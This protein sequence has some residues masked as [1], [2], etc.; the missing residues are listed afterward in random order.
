M[1]KDTKRPLTLFFD[2]TWKRSKNVALA[3]RGDFFLLRLAG[4]R[5]YLRRLA[6]RLS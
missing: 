6:R 5:R 2:V 3:G 4:L 1:G